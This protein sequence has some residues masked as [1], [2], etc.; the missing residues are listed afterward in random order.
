[1]MHEE[2]EKLT[3]ITVSHGYYTEHIEPEYVD[4]NAD[5]ADFCAAWIKAHKADVCKALSLDITGMVRESAIADTA[6]A[7]LNEM[8]ARAANAKNLEG[9]LREAEE[10][11]AAVRRERDSAFQQRKEVWEQ[12]NEHERTIHARN[13]TIE[14]QKLEILTIKAMLFDALYKTA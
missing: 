8:K 13:E 5:K 1:M 4:Q 9:E 3:G 2:F 7:Q 11:L 12:V 6:I 14:A 10:H